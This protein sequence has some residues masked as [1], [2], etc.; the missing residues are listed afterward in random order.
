MNGQRFFILVM[1][2]WML[3]GCTRPLT[4]STTQS[5]DHQSTT[6]SSRRDSTATATTYQELIRLTPVRVGSDSVDFETQLEVQPTGQLKPAT[7]TSRSRRATVQLKVDAQGKVTGR[8]ACDAEKATIASLDREL[9]QARQQVQQ[10]ASTKSEATTTSKAR[11]VSIPVPYTTW[12]DWLA[13][14]VAIGLLLLLLALYLIHRFTYK[15]DG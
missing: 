6:Q 8:C 12:Y 5:T 15:A 10:R 1:L 9:S 2:L 13:R 14:I 4:T 7:Y 3:E 11:Q